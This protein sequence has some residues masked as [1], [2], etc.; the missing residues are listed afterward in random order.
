MVFDDYHY[1]RCT[2]KGVIVCDGKGYC[3]QHD[4][5]A[6][7]E[8]ARVQREKYEA[9]RSKISRA[10]AIAQAK[11]RVV[12]AAKAWRFTGLANPLA[13]ALDALAELEKNNENP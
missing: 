10:Q 4:P 9:S 3:N 1:H 6:V 7:V 2:R 8:K 12:E 5:M 13:S 11:E